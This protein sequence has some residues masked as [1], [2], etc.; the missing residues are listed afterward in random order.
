MQNFYSD[1]LLG[2]KN[3]AELFALFRVYTRQNKSHPARKKLGKSNR[4]PRKKHSA[5]FGTFKIAA[6]NTYPPII[7]IFPK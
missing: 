5:I 1:V 6:I 3:S 2:T 4:T 7:T